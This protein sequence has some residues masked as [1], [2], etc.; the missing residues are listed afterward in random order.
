[1]A[2]SVATTVARQLSSLPTE[3]SGCLA[4]ATQSV[5]SM[6][7]ARVELATFSKEN[8]TYRKSI[9]GRKKGSWQTVSPL[10]LLGSLSSLP[11]RSMTHNGLM[12]FTAICNHEE[13]FSHGD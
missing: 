2:D 5:P 13:C 6:Y 8:V 1:M 11:G 9:F 3:M 7:Q 4:T 10:L 12:S